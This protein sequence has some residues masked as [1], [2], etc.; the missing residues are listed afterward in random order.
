M[1]SEISDHD[2]FEKVPT[3]ISGFDK[4]AHGGLPKGR[5]TLVSGTAGSGKTIMAVQYLQAGLEQFDESGVLVTFE[6]EPEDMVA[7]V[8]AFGWDMNQHIRNKR[9]IIIDGTPNSDEVVFESGQFD[10]SALMA[11]IETAVKRINAKRVSLDAVSALFPQFTD[12]HIIRRELHRIV[13]GLRHMGVTTIVT[14][15]RTEE[16]GGVARFG[17]EEFVTDNV[18]IIRNRLEHERRRRTVE[19]LKFRG[20]VHSAGEFPFTIDSKEGMMIIPLSAIELIQRSSLDRISS[21]VPELDTMCGG[22]M[23]RDSIIL[24]SG[25]TGTGKTLMVTQF[26]RSAVESGQRYLLFAFEESEFQL[27]RNATSWGTDFAK[28]IEDGHLRIVCCYPESRSLED[29]LVHIIREI[30]DFGPTRIAVDSLSALERVSTI[31]SFR[32]FIIGLTSA[33]KLREIAGMFTNT[34]SMLLGG[35]SVTETHISTITDSIILLRYVELHGEM[36][37]GITVLKMRG[38]WHDKNIRE[39]HIDDVGMHIGE[40]FSGVGG[41]LAGNPVYDFREE[42]KQLSN[43]FGPED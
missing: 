5:A 18:I 12:F 25:A 27:I 40:A 35:E 2:M 15:E 8:A 4:I 29:H 13:H 39:Y 14:M 17:V 22:G 33:V 3:G 20:A 21:G 26:L 23:F 24:V 36:R 38:S 31:R 9:L 1:A 41:I 6:E 11:R 30:D 16:D 10:L 43:L 37:R 28:A 7:N 42:H 19:V 34:T 32:E